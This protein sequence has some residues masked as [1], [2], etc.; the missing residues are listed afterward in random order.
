MTLKKIL[1]ATDFSEQAE[2]AMKHAMDIAR[3]TGAEIILMHALSVPSADFATPYPV[4]TPGLFGEQVKEILAE[5]RKRLEDEREALLGQGVEISHVFVDDMP[6]RGI[7]QAAE[8]SHADLI[9]VGTHGRKGLSRFLVGS[10]AQRVAQRAHCDVLV[11]RG[12][13]PATGYKRILVPTDFSDCSDRAVERALALLNSDGQI[14]LV[15]FWELPGGSVTYWGS[16]GPGLRENIR[17]G[18]AEYGEKLISRF[19]DRGAKVHFEEE[20]SDPRHGIQDRLA[21]GNY[22]LVVMGSHGRK[23]LN[24]LLLGSVAEATIR[25]AEYPVYIARADED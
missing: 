15:H 25:H 9:V 2:G 12:A 23:G 3:H 13:A 22:D 10:V 6:D 5:G 8:D 14:D 19:S 21:S 20:E 11:A 4:A 18:A 16:V 24:R 7:L 1:V 17:K